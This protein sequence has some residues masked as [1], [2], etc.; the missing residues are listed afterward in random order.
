MDR[1]LWQVLHVISNH[2]KKVA[3]HLMVRS[4]EHFLPLYSDRA[5]WSDRTVSVQRPLFSGY[6]FAR[7]SPDCRIA[8]ISIPG[9]LRLLGNEEHNMVSHEEM[10]KIRI[11]LESG[12][13]IRP[14]SCVEVGTKV[15]VREGLFAGVEGVVTEF[16]RECRVIIT[17]A[18]VR[19]CFSLEVD[20]DG[21]EVLDKLTVNKRPKTTLVY[22]KTENDSYLNQLSLP[23]SQ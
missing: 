13:L 18:A 3:Q 15:R 20:L 1:G 17:L 19:Q 23:L 11:G 12:L 8:V 10:D 2:E 22:D 9:V 5:K 4:V 21:I 14:H 6:V 16:R 7:F